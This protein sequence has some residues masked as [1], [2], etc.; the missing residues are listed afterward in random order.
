MKS[1]RAKPLRLV[2]IAT[3]FTFVVV[4][5]LSV[6]SGVALHSGYNFDREMA[7][8]NEYIISSSLQ[9]GVLPF[10]LATQDQE[11]IKSIIDRY[12]QYEEIYGIKVMD[13]TGEVVYRNE[14]GVS[15]TVEIVPK[16]YN[17]LSSYDSVAIDGFDPIKQDALST[18][19]T[20]TIFFSS[21]QLENN[22]KR[23]AVFAGGILALAICCIV[24]LLY[25][26]NRLISTYLRTAIQ[27]MGAVEKGERVDESQIGAPL[28]DEVRVIHRS[29]K[30]LS[31]STFERNL[32]LEKSLVEALQAKA[33][34]LKA[35]EFKDDVIR[36]ISH[37]IRTPVG[38]IVNL[39]EILCKDAA[40]LKVHG[41]LTYKLDACYQSAKILSNVTDE[42]FDLEQ[43]QRQELI[44]SKEETDLQALFSGI[45]CLYEQR[46]A[47]KRIGFTVTPNNENHCTF[48]ASVYLD[49]R[50]VTLILEN[51]IDNA[52]KFTKSGS[53]SVEWGVGNGVVCVS[54]KDSGR[55]IPEDKVDIIFG[56][57]SQLEN[58][59]SCRH[60][61]RGLG[62]Y[63]VRR[64]LDF[65]GGT[66][67][68]HS[69]VGIGSVFKLSIPFDWVEVGRNSQ[70]A[71]PQSR[72]VVGLK[73]LVIDDDEATCFTLKQMLTEHNVDCAVECIP[74]IGLSRLIKDAPDL[75][76]IDYHMPGLSGDRLAQK[77]Q[78][79]L[80]PN[81]TFFVCITAECNRA[82]IQGLSDV[83][84]DVYR[85][86]FKSQRLGEI[87]ERVIESKRFTSSVISSLKYKA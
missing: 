48:P 37:D 45:R 52:L 28:I 35:E 62:L 29:L 34:A 23:Q 64:L 1:F 31:E 3:V 18:L 14:R 38:V 46:F 81:A 75:V 6:A 49:Q 79:S 5:A 87:L 70:S 32:Q 24:I 82:S 9:G 55:G 36:A 7:R 67:E 83:F 76:F 68:V 60:E 50:K 22:V 80:S 4:I 47:D 84:Q 51:I 19:A 25:L 43:F 10:A 63:Y 26:F 73:A 15:G 72:A 54:V 44:S 39:L 69:K 85:K 13:S 8:R 12:L 65:I 57:H 40:K 71:S 53:V 33:T 74:E 61:G 78:L 21:E 58:P 86:P 56:K 42:L 41:A 27:L 66:V 20:V 16:T 77:A 30:H 17:I 11:L 2:T 59:V